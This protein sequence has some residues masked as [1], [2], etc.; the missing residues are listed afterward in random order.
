MLASLG[1]G[2]LHMAWPPKRQHPGLAGTLERPG[3]VWYD[4]PDFMKSD[5]MMG[6]SR[7]IVFGNN[8]RPGVMLASAARTYINRHGVAPGSIAVV[9]SS[10]DDG[11]STIN[12]LTA[13]GITVDL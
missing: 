7:P 3:T 6:F 12:D 4:P 13:A 9:F 8:D 10:N 11:A 1:A 2:R 5:L